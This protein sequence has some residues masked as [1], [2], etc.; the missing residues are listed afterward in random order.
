M[1]EKIVDALFARLAS[2]PVTRSRI[3]RN[4]YKEALLSKDVI[5]AVS[6]YLDGPTSWQMSCCAVA[7]YAYVLADNY[8]LLSSRERQ[9]SF[10]ACLKSAKGFSEDRKQMRMRQ[11]LDSPDAMFFDMLGSLVKYCVANR[12][13]I[14]PRQ[15]L[16]DTLEW[17]RLDDAVRKR[18]MWDFC[19]KAKAEDNSQGKETENVS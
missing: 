15:L 13:R 18:W 16:R 3:R 10:G 1:N 17:R 8:N 6:P 9:L 19:A 11:L 4:G 14:D 5:E 7:A 12:A 2:A